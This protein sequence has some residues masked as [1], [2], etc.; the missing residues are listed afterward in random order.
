[1]TRIQRLRLLTSGKGLYFFCVCNWLT[2][3]ILGTLGLM[4]WVKGLTLAIT[5]LK[6][7]SKS[8]KYGKS[9]PKYFLASLSE[10]GRAFHLWY[11]R[12]LMTYKKLYNLWKNVDRS[13]MGTK[14]SGFRTGCTGLPRASWISVSTWREVMPENNTI[15]I[16]TLLALFWI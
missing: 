7:F 16:I 1:M 4:S 15:L 10:C 13:S 3:M 8:P 12:H 11:R 5:R 2:S 9:F 14:R 6:F